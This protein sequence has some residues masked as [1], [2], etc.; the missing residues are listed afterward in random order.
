MSSRRRLPSKVPDHTVACGWDNPLQT[1]FCTVVRDR[2]AGD[3]E[4]DD[5]VVLWLG[6]DEREVRT[7]EALVGPLAPYAELDAAMLSLLR[8]DRAADLDR[9]PSVLQRQS[10]AAIKRRRT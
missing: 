2:V 5:L 4:A 8:A 1:Y 6:L 10:L 9:G 7:P 3:R